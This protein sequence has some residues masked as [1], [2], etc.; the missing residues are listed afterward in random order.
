MTG[1][2]L[3]GRGQKILEMP[4]DAWKKE[5]AQI[6]EHSQDRLAFMTEAHQR[7]RYFVVKE[8]VDRQK[9][10]EAEYIAEKLKMP[11]ETVQGILEEL[12]RKL[13]S[14]QKTGEVADKTDGFPKMP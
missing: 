14:S 11:L 4:D 7:V 3:I 5:L 6:P 12:E 1:K 2:I 13:V 10:L 9:P 8:L